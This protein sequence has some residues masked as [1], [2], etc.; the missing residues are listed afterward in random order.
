MKDVR[1]QFL[2]NKRVL[3]AVLFVFATYGPVFAQDADE[4][5]RRVESLQEADT[6]AMRVSMHIYDRLEATESRDLY[7]ETYG[8]GETESY[9]EFVS[10]RS[11]AGLRVLDLD[12]EVRVFF[13]STGRV[14]RITGSQR[15]GSVGG[16]GG[17]FSYEDMGGGSLT[18][19]YRFT[20]QRQD[21][22]HYTIRGVPVDSES[23]YSHLLFY[24]L[25]DSFLI[26]RIEYFTPEFGHEKTMTAE[27]FQTIQSR[28]LATVITMENHRKRQRTVLQIH[29]AA[30]DVAIDDRYF[31]PNRFYR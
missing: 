7:L 21:G 25:R 22:E 27:E 15:G 9:T 3:L 16:V 1:R 13:P 23:S 24:V 6:S 18:E 31:N 12:G 4:I 8:R 26:D 17:D 29:Q 10:P 11:I 14:R 5:M 30:F 2:A 28:E 19:D 20:L